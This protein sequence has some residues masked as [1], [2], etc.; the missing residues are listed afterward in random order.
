L[1]LQERLDEVTKVFMDLSKS[2]MIQDLKIITSIKEVN[3]KTVA[4]FLAE[5]VKLDNFISQGNDYIKRFLT[6]RKD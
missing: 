5:M 2:M 1:Y 4:P 3:T 6:D